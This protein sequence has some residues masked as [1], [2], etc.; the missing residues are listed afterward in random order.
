MENPTENITANTQPKT[1]CISV[2][3][4]RAHLGNYLKQVREGVRQLVVERYECPIVVI[5]PA[6][7]V[8][9]SHIHSKKVSTTE[10]KSKMGTWLKSGTHLILT[11]RNKVIAT[12]T[13]FQ[14]NLF[15]SSPTFN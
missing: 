13:P 7:S 8:E 6:Q 12:V 14:K 11:N 10:F 2:T 9:L 4:L 3:E 15:P 1:E 5:E